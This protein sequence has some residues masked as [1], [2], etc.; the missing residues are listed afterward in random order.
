MMRHGLYW[1]IRYG[2][3][4]YC[5]QRALQLF[6]REKQTWSSEVISHRLITYTP[7]SSPYS[8]DGDLWQ[9]N[10]YQTWILLFAGK[11]TE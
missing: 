7:T 9:E 3:K 2:C 4:D 5:Y 10:G 8:E 1:I 6:T 11:L